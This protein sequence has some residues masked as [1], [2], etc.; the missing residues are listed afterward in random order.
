M[1]VPAAVSVVDPPIIIVDGFAVMVTTHCAFEFTESIIEAIR[2]L[3]SIIFFMSVEFVFKGQDNTISGQSH[4]SKYL[5]K[6]I[7]IL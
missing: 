4:E 2:T 5:K 3:R 7:A 6:A 1:V